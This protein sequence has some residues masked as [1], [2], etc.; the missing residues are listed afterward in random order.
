MNC[1]V[2][3]PPNRSMLRNLPNMFLTGE[4]FFAS[5]ANRSYS[6]WDD[7]VIRSYCG[8]RLGNALT[9]VLVATSVSHAD[10][11]ESYV[12]TCLPQRNLNRAARRLLEPS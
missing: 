9:I 10:D 4:V 6:G 2:C 5:E 11:L 12:L 8:H 7:P 3:W 1:A